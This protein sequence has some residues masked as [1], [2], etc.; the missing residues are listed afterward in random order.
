MPVSALLKFSTDLII[1]IDNG[2]RVLDANENALSVLGLSREDLS[3]NRIETINSPLLARLAIPDVFD[4]VQRSGEIL[5]E[6]S[7]PSLNEELHYRVRLIPTIFDNLEEGITIIGEDITEQVRFEQF[8]M[9]SEAR[10]RGIVQDQTDFI[11]RGSP[12]GTVTFINEPLAQFI[13]ISC[14]DISGKSFFPYIF[15]EDLPLAVEKMA[16]LTPDQS[17]NTIEIR[18]MNCNGTFRWNIWS[19]RGIFDNTGNLVEW[20]SVGRDITER[21]Q[22]EET[23]TRIQKAVDSSSEAIGIATPDGRHIYQN[24]ALTKM[25][26]YTT[27]E[28]ARSS[29]PII[30]YEDKQKGREIFEA[31]MQGNSCSGEIVVISKD[32]RKFDASYHADAIKDDKG[33]II[34]LIGIH[35]DITERKQVEKA[36]SESELLYRTI[37]DNIQDVYFRADPKGVLV[38]ASPS[39][40]KLLGYGSL[41]EIIGQNIAE[42]FYFEPEERKKFVKALY[43][44]QKISD[45]EITLKKPDGSL[46]EI[47]TNS[48]LLFDSEGHVTGIEGFFRDITFN[49]NAERAIHESEERYRNVVEDQT[50]FICRFTPDRTHIFVNEAY[51]R[52]FGMKREEIMGTRFRPVVH[53]DD[54]EIVAR[55]FSS[56][57]P[58]HPVEVIDQRTIMPDGSIRWQR[59]VD[60]AIFQLDGS[61]KEYQSVG[62][63]I[64]ATK[65]DEEAL[66]ESEERF[67]TLLERVQSVAVQ[68]YLPDYTVVYWNEANAHM[69]GYTAE[70]AIGRDIR[71]LLVPVPARDEVTTAIARMA[72]TGIPEPSAELEML[73]KDGSLVPVFSSHA[74]VKIPGRSTV[75]FCFDVD[76]SDRKK[77]EKAI[78][79]SEERYRN[80]VED[81]T[82]F[83]CRFTP[84]G[85]HV[86]VNEAYC[87]YFELDREEI[88]GSRF[89]PAIHPEDR[90]NVARLFASLTP[91]NQ[92]GVI[93]QRIIMPDGSIRWQRWADRA[94]F[95]LDGSLKEYQSVG[96]DITERKQLEE[97]SAA[98]LKR[99]RDQQA[100]LGTIAF[101]P[102]LFSGDVLELC[103]SLTEVS[104]G[105]L[106]VERVSVWLFNCTGDELR[107]IDLYEARINRHSSGAVLERHEYIPEFDALSKALFIDADDPL[108]DPRTAGYVDGYLKP[109]RITSMLDTVIRVTGQNLGVLCFEHVDRPH[110]W[111]SDEIT[112]ACQLADQVAITLMNHDHRQA[113]LA[114]R[115]SE[116]RYRNVVEDQTE[117][118]C[119]FTPDGKITFCNDAYCRYFGLQKESCIGGPHSVV[120]PPEDARVMQA[121]LA[122][123]T[124]KNPVKLVE[125]RILMPDGNL[126]WHC[127]S[128]R[129]IFGPGGEVIEYQ[130]VGRDITKKMER[131]EKIR[132]SEERFHMIANLSPFPISI[133]DDASNYRYLNTRFERLFG[134]TLA[135]IPT[136][137]NWFLKAFPNDSE[138]HEA[139]ST[140]KND[141]AHSS[142]ET[143][144]SRVYPVTCKDGTVRQVRFFAVTLADGE[145]FVVYE[146]LT[147]KN[148]LDRLRSVL[149]S[150]V[151][152]SNDAIIGKTL[153]G[154]IISWNNAAERIYG[155]RADEIIG[156]SIGV[157]ISP[158]LR[159]QLPTFLE[160][161]RNGERIEHFRT[162]RVRKD[163]TP[164]AVSITLSPIRDENGGISGIST[165][166]R[167]IS[168]TSEFD[169]RRAT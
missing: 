102:Y 140:W 78:R 120:L 150:I 143:A 155:Y 25:F 52:Y 88:I 71:E 103:T 132:A 144:R 99:A 36:L 114:L 104:S 136:G 34:G 156:K 75:Q 9:V 95:Q 108:T 13:G 146:D 29:L 3:G 128:D 116:T 49:K 67:R 14:S 5:R 93:D 148:E 53:P 10:Y 17:T 141:L 63:D 168:D 1:L 142:P 15:P 145:Q 22:I 68:G 83:I 62:R 149:A 50:E 129:A 24:P 111:D 73:H 162:I 126:V 153:D 65:H 7:I 163:G 42:K 159:D 157:I 85:T 48:R 81:Q 121:H 51:C 70:E 60:R 98:A 139:I 131:A 26:G 37:L 76:L 43:E 90:E 127:W 33:T 147:P 152:S 89:H 87:R 74:V 124:P 2:M 119:R 151:D 91:G 167:N 40:P 11:C 28:F 45:Y 47:S 118:I 82:E 137:K 161:V 100:A 12:D 138:R 19:S 20:Q 92:V 66:R 4:E 6:F 69:Y 113:E 164:V 72:E 61:L 130:S 30:A 31:I 122:S 16:G 54:R 154:T 84:D 165:I 160:R 23:L 133:M 117:F 64:T 110:H 21:K 106:G 115:E 44:Q 107:C 8:L 55:L 58:E 125:H 101:S 80:V 112:F 56:L 134:Y 27:E 77:A 94:I 35:T 105:V 59:W 166:A 123:L 38:M 86:F 135:D 18:V 39:A 96:R 169:L 46:V 41:D 32:G 158:E 109:N 57:T 79:E 97:T